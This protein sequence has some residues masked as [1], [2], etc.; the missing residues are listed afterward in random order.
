MIASEFVALL[1]KHQL[2]FHWGAINKR[3]W[4]S[5]QS[6]YNHHRDVV[7]VPANDFVAA[8]V[9]AK[10]YIQRKFK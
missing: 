6:D 4:I 2:T 5:L 9:A 8:Q 3:W 1:A 7:T 10:D